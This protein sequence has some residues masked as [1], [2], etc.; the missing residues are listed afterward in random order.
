MQ[1]RSVFFQGL[2]LQDLNKIKKYKIKK[3]LE[4]IL[5][6]FHFFTKKQNVSKLDFC[7]NHIKNNYY[8][9]SVVFGVNKLSEISSIINSFKKKNRKFKNFSYFSKSNLMIDIRYII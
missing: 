7:I 8:I 1:A 4:K 5:I 3:D 6:K 2:L 9:D